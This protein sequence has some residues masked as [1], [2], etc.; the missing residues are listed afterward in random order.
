MWPRAS[1]M[2]FGEQKNL[3]SGYR[4]DGWVCMVLGRSGESDNGQLCNTLYTVSTQQH[5]YSNIMYAIDYTMATFFW[6]FC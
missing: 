4:L 5:Q 1:L 2:G 3:V 6:T